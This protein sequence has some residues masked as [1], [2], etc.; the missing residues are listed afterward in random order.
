[1]YKKS[2]EEIKFTLLISAVM[3]VAIY[4][5]YSYMMHESEFI[6]S[7]NMTIKYED[8]EVLENYCLSSH[9][10]LDQRLTPHTYFPYRFMSCS[11]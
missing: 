8:D 6:W 4:C 11:L 10:H 1:M 3:H 5:V 2:G 7:L 9:Y